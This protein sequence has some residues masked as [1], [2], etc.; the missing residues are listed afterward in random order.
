MKCCA[1]TAWSAFCQ[2]DAIRWCVLGG[3][4]TA[5]RW[6]GAKRL[7]VLGVLVVLGLVKVCWRCSTTSG[8][9]NCSVLG[10]PKCWGCSEEVF[11]FITSICQA[12]VLC[13]PVPLLTCWGRFST[14]Y[15]TQILRILPKLMGQELECHIVEPL[16]VLYPLNRALASVKSCAANHHC[17]RPPLKGGSTAPAR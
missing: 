2:V 16:G 17:A 4:E 5:V 3:V 14:Q 13:T 6:G 12:W 15:Q 7:S 9:S 1:R 8:R 10:M 11:L